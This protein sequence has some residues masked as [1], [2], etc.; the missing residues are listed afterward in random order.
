MGPQRGLGGHARALPHPNQPQV[1]HIRVRQHHGCKQDQTPIAHLGVLP[2]PLAPLLLV[3]GLE[4]LAFRG[5][6]GLAL[7]LLAVRRDA[8]QLAQLPR[9]VLGLLARLVVRVDVV[10][11]GRAGHRGRRR[12]A[13]QLQLV[14]VELPGF[15]LR[16]A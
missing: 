13:L 5:F 11:A 7:A 8:R 16:R 4:P 6:P 12:R 2:L 15:L 9:L 3:H 14:Q 10:R 1:E